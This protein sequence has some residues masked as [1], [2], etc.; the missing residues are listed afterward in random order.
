MKDRIILDFMIF[1]FIVIEMYHS[2]KL[3]QEITPILIFILIITGIFIYGD[4]KQ[5]KEKEQNK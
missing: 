2:Y 5:I 1:I 4:Y 3:Y